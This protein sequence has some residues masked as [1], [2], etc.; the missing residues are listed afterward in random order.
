MGPTL[1]VA[2]YFVLWW[3]I[4]FAV[5][6]LGVR[7]QHEEGEVTPGSDHGAP[8]KPRLAWKFMI[9]TVVTTIV[10]V[11]VYVV[12]NYNLISLDQFPL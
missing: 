8:A 12:V 1:S 6:P 5:L 4:L 3:T 10:F 7:N 11:I 9:T 2:L